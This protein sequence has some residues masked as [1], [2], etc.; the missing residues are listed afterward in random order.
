MRNTLFVLL[1]VS[2]IILTLSCQQPGGNTT[3]SEY[4]PDMAHSIAY[5]ANV[6]TSYSLNTWDS[7]SV[8]TR[9]DLVGPRDPVSGTVPR[10]YAGHFYANSPQEQLAV[11][12]M[13]TGQQPGAIATPVN[14]HVPYYYEDTEED[15][16]RAIAEIIDNPFPITEAGLAR[17]EELYVI[18]CG[19][20]HGDKGDGAGYL[21]RDPD[22]AKGDVGGKYP[23]APA[24]FLLDEHV[25]ASNGRY[26]HAIMY[27]KNAMGAYAD[28]LSYEERWQVIH[29]IR[30]LQAKERK[31]EYSENANTFNTAF[32][33]PGASLAPLAPEIQEEAAPEEAHEENGDHQHDG[34][35]H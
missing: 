32:G 35:H 12:A 4:M 5:E 9:K 19:V 29:Y 28:K 34:G 21:V 20:C 8:Y 15:R 17:G 13:L 23:A 6:Y 11:M 31:A 24:N 10:G 7:A 14:G 1:A 26:Y 25:N 18:F 30:A 33:V 3:G 27:G 16:Q 2:L 22:P